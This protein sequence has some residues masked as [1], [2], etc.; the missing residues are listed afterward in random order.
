MWFHEWCF[1][2]SNADLFTDL[3]YTLGV[4][5]VEVNEAISLDDDYIER[6][7]PCHGLIFLFK[8]KQTNTSNENLVK[9]ARLHEICFGQQIY[10]NVCPTQAILSVL[11]NC[12]HEDLNLGATLT[13]FKEYSQKFHSKGVGL[14]D[15]KMKGIALS[16]HEPIRDVHNRFAK[17]QLIEFD[18]DDEKKEEY[19]FHFIVYVPFKDHLYELDGLK[20]APIDHGAIPE[21]NEWLDIARP[22]VQ[23]HI[24]KFIEDKIHFRLMVIVSEP[25]KKYERELKQVLADSSLTDDERNAQKSNLSKLINEEKRKKAHRIANLRRQHNLAADKAKKT[26]TTTK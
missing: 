1:I 2:E 22:I 14:F 6:I 25:D 15:T 10:K 11:L 21:D 20:T 9:G 5:G 4:D 23:Q 24:Q 13:E 17:K 19:A 16:N 18:S 7:K 8:Q 26:T 12:T 3:I